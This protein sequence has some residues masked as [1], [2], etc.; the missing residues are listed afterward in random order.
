VAFDV[1]AA[2]LQALEAVALRREGGVALRD[3]VLRGEV[4]LSEARDSLVR[5]EDAEITALVRLNNALRRDASLPVRPADGLYPGTLAV[6][7]AECLQRAAAQ[8]PEVGVA[9]DRVAVV[10][11]FV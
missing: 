9:R 8:R 4:Q 3:D 11:L 1:A 10:Q 5:A 2:Y 7:L 6:S